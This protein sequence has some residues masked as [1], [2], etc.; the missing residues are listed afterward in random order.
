MKVLL[1]SLS[2]LENFAMKFIETFPK[3]GVFGL[4]GS[5]GVGKTT[6]VKAVVADLCRRS[7]SSMPRVVSPSFVV[8]Q[9]YELKP[10][11]DHFDFYR[12]ELTTA[13]S[14]VEIGYWEAFERAKNHNAYVFVEWPEKAARQNLYLTAELQFQFCPEGRE[15]EIKKK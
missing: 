13:E 3:G 10:E 2:D 4:Y 1:T 9:H 12:L 15:V 14:L 5:L 6:F 11:V 8:H 7:G